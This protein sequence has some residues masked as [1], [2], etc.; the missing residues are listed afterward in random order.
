[1]QIESLI[2]KY[3]CNVP[4]YTSY[5]T[6]NHFSD[7]V[8]AGHAQAWLPH[9]SADEP[10]S[11]YLHVPFCRKLCTYCGCH[12]KILD[13]YD[14]AT[15]YVDAIRREI[16]TVTHLI[17]KRLKVA[18]VAWGG[19]T[20]TFLSD[21]DMA[22]IMETV[23]RSFD[24]LDTAE[25]AMEI[26]PRTLEEGRAPFIR[27]LGVNRAS[28]GVQDFD[29]DVQ[30]AINRVQPF[31]M[32]RDCA[33]WLREVG[34]SSINFDLIYGLPLQ[35]EAKF[36]RTIEQSLEL[37]P[38][39]FAVFGY[40][41]VPWFKKHQERLEKWHLPDS[42]ERY[43]LYNQTREMLEAAGYTEIGIDHFTA[44][45]DKMTEAFRNGT[46]R[47]NFQ[48]YTTDNCQTL[49]AFGASAISAL[50]KGYIQNTPMIKTYREQ[51]S[52]G[53]LAHSR[54]IKINDEDRA[55][56]AVIEKIMCFREVDFGHL[57]API[58]NQALSRLASY[59]QDGLVEL[60]GCSL[61][62]TEKGKIF[63]RLI[64]TAFDAYWQES[65]TKHAKAV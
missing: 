5:P 16:E 37:A 40:A 19:G 20:P 41:H 22:G 32:V 43:R 27:N 58:R 60:N 62:I 55:R 63:T 26:D 34:I 39:R 35:T 12:T 57:E 1:M 53:L 3:D 29:A 11:L 25:H 61:K 23:N 6:A 4:R 10:V 47:R 9:L 24:I 38:E 48:G 18:Y 14:P 28:F 51:A 65:A 42:Q 33:R 44:P 2:R 31:E 17:G 45:G 49:L 64:C 54:G 46:L 56:R 7:K 13:H 30:E 21:E 36:S 59:Q 52:A 8:G 15:A 50:P